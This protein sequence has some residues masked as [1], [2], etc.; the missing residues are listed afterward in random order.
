MSCSL[1]H[2]A[3]LIGD[4]NTLISSMVLGG[5]PKPLRVLRHKGLHTLA[6]ALHQ[7]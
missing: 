2:P 1:V 5:N 3:S 6:I 7:S 4:T